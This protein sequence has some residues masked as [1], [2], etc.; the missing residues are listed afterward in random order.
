MA[1]LTPAEAEAEAKARAEPRLYGRTAHQADTIVQ[2]AGVRIGGGATPTFIAGPC[3]AESPEQVLDAAWAAKRA[4]A[5][6]FRAGVK[7]PRSDPAHAWEGTGNVA[8]DWLV[9]AR[10]E[11]GLPVTTEVLEVADVERYARVL[12]LFWIGSRSMQNA[13]LIRAVAHT[14]KPLLL[15]RGAAAT[16]DE[17]LNMAEVALV[18]GNPQVILCERGIVTYDRAYTRNLLD[19]IA[20]P[21]VRSLSHLP[22]VVDPSHG[23]GRAELVEQASLA[24][25]AIGAAGLMIEM[26]P[27]PAAS[28]TDAAQ[29]IDPETLATIIRRAG[30][31]HDAVR[32]PLD[33]HHGY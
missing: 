5:H 14:G 2:V 12:D 33:T 4:G 6:L 18:E 26:H 16:I 9:A 19:L 1:L 3:A 29:A 7:K 15:K 22:V 27:T 24:A 23:T 32:M 31:V 21:V 28:R 17:W 25:V 11:T 13:A 20:V 30:L 10:D 8:L